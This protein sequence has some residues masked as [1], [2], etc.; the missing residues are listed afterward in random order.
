MRDLSRESDMAIVEGQPV[1]TK[2]PVLIT[3][4]QTAGLVGVTAVSYIINSLRMEE[5]AYLKSRSIP[6]DKMILGSEFRTLNPFRMYL[7]STGD[8]LALLNDSPTGLLGLS[9]FFN[10]IGKTLLDWF[11][12]KDG[13]LVVIIGSYLLPKDRKP[14]LF[15]F[16]TDSK[17]LEELTEFGIRPLQQGFIGGLVV[18]IIDECIE[19]KIPWLMLFAPTRKIGEVD[20]EGVSM[21]LDGINKIMGLNIETPPLPQTSDTKR[22]SLR[23][24][25]RR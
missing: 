24:L 10:D 21:I 7:N 1:K 14:E 23:S 3:G 8:V 12:K 22:R 6:T 18:R 17:R 20:N 5:V 9:P 4:F 25:I 2:N 15:A 11:H 16:S 19:R 13:R